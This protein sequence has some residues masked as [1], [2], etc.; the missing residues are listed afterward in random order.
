MW[1]KFNNKE[2]SLVVQQ[3]SLDEERWGDEE[4]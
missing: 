1:T 4:R 3:P 2:V